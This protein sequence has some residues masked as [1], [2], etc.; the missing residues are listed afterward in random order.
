MYY[1]FLQ[2]T[3]FDPFF[4]VYIQNDPNNYHMGLFNYWLCLAVG[5]VEHLLVMRAQSNI[6]GVLSLF[7]KIIGNRM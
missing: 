2:I 4:D 7:V 5:E 1:S 3:H 6:V